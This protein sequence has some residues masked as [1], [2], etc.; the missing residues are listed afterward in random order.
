MEIP[1]PVP[2]FLPWI[3]TDNRF[4]DTDCCCLLIQVFMTKCQQE[5]TSTEDKISSA[6]VEMNSNVMT[7]NAYVETSPSILFAWLFGFS[8]KQFFEIA[9]G[10][11]MKQPEV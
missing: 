2:C 11:T 4:Q 6:R 9:E 1:K 3:T 8:R 7:Y 5:L 10:E